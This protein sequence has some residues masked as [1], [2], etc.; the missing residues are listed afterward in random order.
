MKKI[1]ESERLI[2]REFSHEDAVFIVE[3]LNTEGWLQYIGDRNVHNED[4]ALDYLESGSIQ[5]YQ[6]KGF[7][8]YG[9]ILK[10]SLK[11]IGMCG[12][13]QRENATDIEIGYAFLP[14]FQQK[15]YASEAVKATLAYGFES[16]KL[17][18][19]IAVARANNFSSIKLLEKLD[20]IHEKN[21]Y[22]EEQNEE[23]ALFG[24]KK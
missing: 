14:T 21:Y 18:R 10:E 6:T 1:I 4:Q 20:F 2:L 9:V 7:G 22:N 24:I 17:E 15:G 23:L 16:L 5:S 12:F 13:I 3:L 8:F 19:I 11:L